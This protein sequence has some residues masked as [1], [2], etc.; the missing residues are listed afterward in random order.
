MDEGSEVEASASA[1][2]SVRR[3]EAIR[4]HL[5]GSESLR[6]RALVLRPDGEPPFL[7]ATSEEH[8]DRFL[9]DAPPVRLTVAFVDRLDRASGEGS[10]EAEGPVLTAFLLAMPS[11]S[12]VRQVAL[13]EQD[14]ESILAPLASLASDGSLTS[15]TGFDCVLL[16]DVFSRVRKLDLPNLLIERYDSRL[17]FRARECKYVRESGASE[18]EDWGDRVP[19]KHC[20]EC[21][22]VF[23]D[24]DEKYTY[25]R[26]T[27]PKKEEEASG[28][29]VAPVAAEEKKKKPVA[30]ARE[31]KAEDASSEDPSGPRRRPGRPKGAKNR[32]YNYGAE[33]VSIDAAIAKEENAEHKPRSKGDGLDEDDEDEEKEQMGSGDNRQTAR[34]ARFLAPVMFYCMKCFQLFVIELISREKKREREKWR[35]KER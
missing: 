1:P 20:S 22:K 4:D 23:K 29:E 21:I 34:V 28:L 3:L 25:S 10:S 13:P 2:A 26:F 16:D 24:L 32:V 5:H 33:F 27:N 9:V 8:V 15:C 30:T 7:T 17:L 11:R 18:E 35:V 19:G 6:L 12:L 31:E 14:W